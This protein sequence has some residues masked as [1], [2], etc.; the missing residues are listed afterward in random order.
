MIYFIVGKKRVFESLFVSKYDILNTHSNFK[1]LS[2]VLDKK[3][4]QSFMIISIMRDPLEQIISYAYHKAWQKKIHL[5]NKNEVDVINQIII[6]N[7]E[8]FFSEN[9]KFFNY[10]LKTKKFFLKLENLDKDILKLSKILDIKLQIFKGLKIRSK[11]RNRKFKKKDLKKITLKK[12]YDNNNFK[13]MLKL[14]NY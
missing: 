13:K 2:R 3:Y 6:D 11:I 5:T 8:N 1:D 4:L 7:Y 10:P 9:E 14:G 12:L